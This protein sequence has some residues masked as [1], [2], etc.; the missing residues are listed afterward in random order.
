MD[1]LDHAISCLEALDQVEKAICPSDTDYRNIV[2][3]EKN[4][5]SLMGLQVQNDAFIESSKKSMHVLVSLNGPLT[6]QGYN[7]VTVEDDHGNVIGGPIDKKVP[8]EAVKLSEGYFVIPDKDHLKTVVHP[9]EPATLG[10]PNGIYE[11]VFMYLSP[12]TSK[13]VR[14]MYLLQG[15]IAMV[16][17]DRPPWIDEEETDLD[18][19]AMEAV[20]SKLLKNDRIVDVHRMDRETIRKAFEE[21]ATVKT[22]S[23]MPMENLALSESKKRGLHVFVTTSGIFDPSPVQYVVLKDYRN[24]TVGFIVNEEDK[25]AYE[26]RSDLY[27]ISDD[28]AVTE[29]FDTGAGTR[30][31]LQPQYLHCIGED[32]N[33]YD[34]ISM[35][36]SPSTDNL[37]KEAYGITDPTLGTA[38]I[39]FD[40]IGL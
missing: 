11:P 32:E 36:P 23:G 8:E 7:L 33:V 25:A 12:K 28:F 13:L 31:V 27:W 5:H 22:M 26:S 34:A 3:E 30:V 39:S 1:P 20:I 14:K 16:S 18:D 38:I 17:F 15:D 21:E 19:L 37:L 29:D 10:G 40:V 9:Y 4:F 24:K 2:R 35:L 6:P